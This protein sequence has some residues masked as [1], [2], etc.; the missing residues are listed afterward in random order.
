MLALKH[1]HRHYVICPICKD[2][3][4]PCII[5][6]A[7]RIITGNPETDEVVVYCDEIDLE[8]DFTCIRKIMN[9]KL[10]EIQGRVRDFYKQSGEV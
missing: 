4:K 2:K 8:K 1:K 10:L 7:E 5:Y 9:F 3:G 6:T